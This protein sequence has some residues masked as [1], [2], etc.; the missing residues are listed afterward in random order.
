MKRKLAELHASYIQTLKRGTSNSTTF[1]LLSKTITLD[2]PLKNI[3]KQNT[4]NIKNN[5]ILTAR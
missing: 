3:I 1:Y 5:L 2:A 4:A